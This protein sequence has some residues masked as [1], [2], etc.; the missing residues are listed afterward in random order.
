MLITRLARE[1]VILEQEDED[2][3]L[4]II[5]III[6]RRRRRKTGNNPVSMATRLWGLTLF[7]ICIMRFII[8]Y[9]N[10]AVKITCE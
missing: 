9:N 4:L 2:E 5:I 8:K 10:V 1:V 3:L 6:I 7:I